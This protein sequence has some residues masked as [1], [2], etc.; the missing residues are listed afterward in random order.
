MPADS[1]ESANA[2]CPNCGCRLDCGSERTSASW[3][4]PCARRSSRK[5]SAECVEW[6]TVKITSESF[7]AS[8]SVRIYQASF[9]RSPWKQ[10]ARCL[11]VHVQLLLVGGLAAARFEF[12]NDNG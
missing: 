9:D 5:R 3:R 6:P 12:H 8:I 11:D 4:M 7:G 10:C 1:S 2:A